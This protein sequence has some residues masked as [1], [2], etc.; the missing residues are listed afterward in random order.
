[1]KSYGNKA[2][3]PAALLSTERQDNMLDFY[4]KSLDTLEV[5][6]NKMGLSD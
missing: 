4:E 6:M 5:L 3:D 2:E 1:V